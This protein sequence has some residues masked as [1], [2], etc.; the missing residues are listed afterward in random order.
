MAMDVTVP[1]LARLTGLETAL[2]LFGSLCTLVLVTGTVALGR[3]LHGR[4]TVL[5]PGSLLFAH[6]SF[7]HLGLFN[8]LL[9]VGAAFWLL[10]GW[11]AA[12]RVRPP[13]TPTILA[14]AAGATLVYACHLAGLG[15]YLLGLL[16][17]EASRLAE[18]G[19]GLERFARLIPPLV[20]AFPAVLLHVVI[21][22]PGINQ[23][24][25]TAG[26]DGFGTIAIKKLLLLAMMPRFAFHPHEFVTNLLTVPLAIALY[27]GLKSGRLSTCRPA[28]GIVAAFAGAV[29]LLPPSGFG[30][31][32]VDVRMALP[33]TLAFWASLDLQSTRGATDRRIRWAIAAAVLLVSAAAQVQWWRSS[34]RQAEMRAALLA[35]GHGSRVAVVSLDGAWRGLGH[36]APAWSVIDRS[37]FLSTLFAR[38]FQPFLLGYRSSLVD[39]AKLARLDNDAPPPSFGPIAEHYDYAVVFGPEAD[40]HAYAA[41]AR[42]LYVSPLA[43]IVA[44]R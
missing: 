10:S 42:T 30:S 26:G 20:Q 33:L 8:F 38:P 37:T 36:H 17:Y 1:L 23:T 28:L 2:K 27:L 14:Y 24:L 6:N 44:L 11:I 19:W 31:N 5:A 34:P 7:L 35:V 22:E 15:I 13:R 16:A 3:A 25:P 43:R 21:Y 12:S 18:R 29:L 41:A 32:L 39:L 9:A 4:V 40:T